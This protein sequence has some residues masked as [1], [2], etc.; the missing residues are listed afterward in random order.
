MNAVKERRIR[1]AALAA[2][3]VVII[4]ILVHAWKALTLPKTEPQ[5]NSGAIAEEAAEGIWVEETELDS[6][7]NITLSLQEAILGAGEQMK[8]LEVFKQ[9]VSDIIKVTDAG[10]LPFNLGA[11][12][13]YIK[14]SGTAIYTVDLSGIDSDHLKVDEEAKT[15]TI[16]I[17]HAVENLSINEDET[18]ADETEN[19]GIFSIGD[20]KQTEEERNEVIARVK[21]NMRQKLADE[22]V[23]ELAD[24]MA[25]MSVWE[26]YQPVV[27]GVSPEY[28]VVTE[29][30]SD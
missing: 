3:A 26:I 1:A 4:I 5:D 28:S 15:I 6:N 29:F 2:A 18:Q 10:K 19:T 24:R 22:N 23:S 8:N 20:L 16:Y 25:K 11:K 12:Y 27:T 13:R 9:N 14:Y 21:N 7:K 30:V 17:P